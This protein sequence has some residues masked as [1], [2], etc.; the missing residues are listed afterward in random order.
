ML[1]TLIVYIHLLA[2]AF[3]LVELLKFDIR[4]LRNL[5]RPLAAADLHRLISTK[6]TVTLALVV[7]WITG[8]WFVVNGVIDE[9]GKYLTNQKLWMKLLTVWLLTVNGMLMHSIGF[10]HL[11]PGVVFSEMALK[12]Q[13]IL[14]GMG[15]VSSVSWMSAA[16]LGIARV[17]NY[18]ASFLDL[19]V[20]YFL[21]LLGGFAAANLPLLYLRL[22]KNSTR[23]SDT[24]KFNLL[25]T[26]S[27]FHGFSDAILWEFLHLSEWR[28]VKPERTLIEEGKAARSFYILANG[29]ASVE[30]NGEPIGVLKVG[31]SF[32]ELAYIREQAT[33]RP[34]TVTTRSEAMVIKIKSE[35]L[36]TASDDL[37]FSLH[38]AFL[39]ALDERQARTD[40]Q[41]AAP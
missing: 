27:L 22:R 23:V 34:A 21:C 9:P 26:L 6:N 25:K 28:R 10:T 3:A 32:G 11:R 35:T 30:K 24:L 41:L 39:R 14:L 12:N 31:D 15:V 5:N 1:K 13:W 40:Y 29:E 19:F 8:I 38:R 2:T 18:T 37:R 17:W 36:T 7:L 16:F 20:I 33:A 4:L